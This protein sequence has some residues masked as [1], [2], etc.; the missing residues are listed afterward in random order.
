M[1]KA[2]VDVYKAKQTFRAPLEYVFDWCT[3]FREDDNKMTGS[4]TKRT[5]LQKTP[6]RIV[7]L[8]EYKE[9]GK[10]REGLRI[11]WPH[12]PDSWVLDTCGDRMEL[13]ERERGEYKLTRKGKNKTRLD[14]KFW[15][16]FDSKEHFQDKKEW[17]KESSEHWDTY[18]KYL[19]K[20]YKDSLAAAKK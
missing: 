17:E 13:G 10:N 5:I 3:D 7:W 9:G 14:M 15:L 19:E 8:V 20:D 18:A 11:V 1:K 2:Y 16:S 6:R 12:P 4:K